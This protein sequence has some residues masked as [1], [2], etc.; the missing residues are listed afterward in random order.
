MMKSEDTPQI[1]KNS[2]ASGFDKAPEYW[3]IIVGMAIYIAMRNA[4]A[5]P[6]RTRLLKALTAGMLAVGLSPELA[7]RIG[8]SEGITAVIIMAFGQIILDGVTGLL[9]DRDFI[10]EILRSYLTKGG[11]K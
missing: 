11:S 8:F 1:V 10:K 6:L 3:F 9:G 5:A 4:E 2:M 7:T